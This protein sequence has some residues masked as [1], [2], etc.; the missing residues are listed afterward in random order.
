M[1][2]PIAIHTTS[3]LQK[4]LSGGI[5]HREHSSTAF[6]PVSRNPLSGNSLSRRSDVVKALQDL[7]VPLLPYFSQ[8]AGVRLD[9]TASY[10]DRAAADFEGFARPLWGLLPLAKG[11]EPF[12]HWH[13]YR[14]GLVNGFDPAHVEYIGSASGRD[15]RLVELAVI[16]FALR[17]CPEIFWEPLDA[18][19]KS[20]LAG[21]LL[22]ARQ[23][24]YVDN[25]WRFF[26][27]LVD[28]GL[29]HVGVPHD[30]HL[31]ESYLDEL[32]GFYI[33]D[34]WYR[35]GNWRQLDHYGPFAMH[36]YGLIYAALAEPGNERAARFRERAQLF[37][38]DFRHWFADD[39][40]CLC[41]GRSMTYRFAM[42]SFWG[43][44]AFADIEALPWGTIKGY[45]LRHLRWWA[46]KP[47][48][49]RDGIL[50]VGYCYPNLL[51]SESYISAGSPYW[52]FKVFLPLALPESDP[53]WQAEESPATP[54]W[55]KP[56]PL[57]HP[58]MVMIATGGNTVALASGQENHWMRDGA[59]K[60][61]KFV[62][63]TRYAF[64]V[65]S[66][67]RSFSHGAFD[68]ALALSEDGVHFRVREHNEDVVIADTS[69]YARWRPWPDV[70]VETWLVAGGLWH[71]RV[72]RIKT[73]RPLLT[74]EGGF[75]IARSDGNRDRFEEGEGM[76][77]AMNDTD[78]SGI[79]D[80]GRRKRRGMAQKAAPNTNLIIAKT[81]VPQLRGKV[82]TGESLL[83]AAFIA[84][85]ISHAASTGWLH[86][87]KAPDI[88]D[89]QKQFATRGERVSAVKQPPQPRR[90]AKLQ[91]VGAKVE[92]GLTRILR[93][94]RLD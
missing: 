61:A 79:R 30:E 8:G 60:Y 26:R 9:A 55:P 33:G 72:H 47:I 74:A 27:V 1:M 89:L 23:F 57:K 43:A 24:E 21:Y 51:M 52:A 91:G 81:T 84:S 53:F 17:L 10:S 38:Q 75:A 67:P 54:P 31:T 46:G 44:L 63:S 85:P 15:Q 86:P 66:D 78:L 93:S 20:I 40:A 92:R 77:L 37:A 73:P 94:I 88:R 16:G 45:Y 36:F 25:N 19:G 14:R 6:D 56:V 34:G 68:G 65:E 18:R 41:Y 28:L 3:I 82:A 48:A 62:Y 50:S 83:V 22:K 59:E 29:K 32:D 80:L 7:F 42:A 11:G 90:I 76:V 2:T 87:P 71:I 4:P 12:D 39:G 49:H 13:L 69:L 64:S 35:D 70:T 58:G 5:A